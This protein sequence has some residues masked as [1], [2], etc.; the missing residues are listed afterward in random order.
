MRLRTGRLSHGTV[1]GVEWWRNEDAGAPGGRQCFLRILPFC[2]LFG[3]CGKGQVLKL[4]SLS[5]KYGTQLTLHW[6]KP[7]FSQSSQGLL[8]K[9]ALPYSVTGTRELPPG[10][11]APKGPSQRSQR[12]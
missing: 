4:S 10:A 11:A 6:T 9:C 1:S 3:I 12:L 2:A 7:K 8:V 5:S